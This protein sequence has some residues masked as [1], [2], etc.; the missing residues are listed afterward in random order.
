M[1][2]LIIR[3]S[4]KE[5]Y[6]ETYDLHFNLIQSS[7][8]PKWID[9]LLNAQQRQDPI[10]EPWAF[11]DCDNRAS[12]VDVQQM[13]NTQIDFCNSISPGLFDRKLEN[14]NDQDCLNYIHSIFELHHGKLDEWLTNPLFNT[15]QG[16]ELR[17]ALSQINQL[18]HKCESATRNKSPK[19][20]VVWFDLPKTKCYSQNDYTLF[21]NDIEFG[22]LY[23]L[24]A[25]V[26][27]NLESLASDND[28][29]VHDFVPN[30]HYSADFQVRF[31]DRNG[32]HIAHRC[33]RYL[34][35]NW[36]YFKSKG[37][38][39]NDPR[40]TTGNIKLAQLQFNDRK[41]ILDA[42]SQYDNIQNVLIF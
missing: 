10:S 25:D 11:Y 24:Y 1:K 9:R 34:Q 21:T 15:P 13:L 5:N 23:T 20:R 6:S 41:E 33:D 32:N 42:L 22:G 18:V 35:D 36:E 12:N 4:Q 19:I 38:S 7:F 14:I 3:L 17:H 27:K 39:K 16:N 2:N 29:H 30:L 31:H 40:L 8:L 28:H 37:Y 26:G